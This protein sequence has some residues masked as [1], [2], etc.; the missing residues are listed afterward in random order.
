MH[1][2]TRCPTHAALSAAHCSTRHNDTG[3]VGRL[4]KARG[5][6]DPGRVSRC[7]CIVLLAL[8]VIHVWNQH[9]KR[10][11]HTYQ[12]DISDESPGAMLMPP[13]FM[14]LFMPDHNRCKHTGTNRERSSYD[15]ELHSL[16]S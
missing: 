9:G 6:P 5:R 1:H 4:I 15:Y 2:S 7:C 12:T 11:N 13:S 8:L 10:C 14:L 16:A 3:V